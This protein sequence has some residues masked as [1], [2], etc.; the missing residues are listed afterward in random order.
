M[1]QSFRA[2]LIDPRGRKKAYCFPSSTRLLE[3]ASWGNEGV[4][5][6][7]NELVG[8]PHRVAWI[9]DLSRYKPSLISR[10][11]YHYASMHSVPA[12]DINTTRSVNMW[13]LYFVN[14]TK[15]LYMD[16]TDYFCNT[17]GENGFGGLWVLHPLPMLTAI[18]NG[19]GEDDYVGPNM[20]LV[21]SWAMDF[22]AFSIFAPAEYEKVNYAFYQ[23]RDQE[24]PIYTDS[25][26]TMFAG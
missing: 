8:K 7:A 24:I 3:H 12:M 20:E 2:L 5:R 17:G 22:V 19:R 25:S 14:H 18:G 13:G 4:N 6:I 11:L 23:T 9:G 10:E 16:C 15:K 1:I 26:N 21:G